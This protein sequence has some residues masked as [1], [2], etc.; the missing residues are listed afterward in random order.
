[1]PLLSTYHQTKMIIM[2]LFI[3]ILVSI[4]LLMI[5]I[6]M[7]N[8][9]S[10]ETSSSTTASAYQELPLYF[11]ANQGQT[12]AEV[13]FISRGAGYTMFLTSAGVTMV[14]ADKITTPEDN[15][16]GYHSVIKMSLI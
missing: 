16:M 8:A 15:Q 1:M 2:D 3:R 7:T 5:T 11:E 6:R 12:D 4:I 13:K 10:L 9:A 14:L